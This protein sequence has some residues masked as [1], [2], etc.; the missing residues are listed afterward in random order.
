MNAPDRPR[1]PRDGPPW[2][3]RDPPHVPGEK[4]RGAEVI[5]RSRLQRWIFFG[6]LAAF[7]IFAIVMGIAGLS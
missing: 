6:G 4:A 3:E 1:G 5:L 2:P 7:V